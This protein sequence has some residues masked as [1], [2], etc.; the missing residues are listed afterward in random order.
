MLTPHVWCAVPEKQRRAA[1]EKPQFMLPISSASS[2]AGSSP[3]PPLDTKV[4]SAGEKVAR[5]PP[6]RV[7]IGRESVVAKG[8]SRS[9]TRPA[10]GRHRSRSGSTTPGA[11]QRRASD[12]DP[13]EEEYLN[14][15]QLAARHERLSHAS[16]QP[17]S[18]STDAASI[19]S[20]L[21]SIPC[22]ILIFVL[23]YCYVTRM[24]RLLYS[25]ESSLCCTLV[26]LFSGRYITYYSCSPVNENRLSY[27]MHS[28]TYFCV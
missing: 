13:V 16:D 5:L 18:V 1:L 10:H 2:N 8:G 12:R 23:H 26:S 11:D 19:A 22:A 21:K 9:P 28:W 24:L 27:I 25:S 6:I 20:L 7:K 17:Q 3:R 14:S 4:E 15:Q